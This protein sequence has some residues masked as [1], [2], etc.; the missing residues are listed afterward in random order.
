MF[1]GIVK[2]GGLIPPQPFFRDAACKREKQG[3]QATKT[4]RTGCLSVKDSPTAKLQD[5]WEPGITFLKGPANCHPRSMCTS[6]ML[7]AKL[8]SC[9]P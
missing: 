1:Q 4:F 8:S 5:A 3:F 6:G 9:I 2:H 7:V